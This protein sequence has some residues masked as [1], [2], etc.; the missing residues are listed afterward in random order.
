MMPPPGQWIDLPPGLDGKSRRVLP[1][2]VVEVGASGACVMAFPVWVVQI[3]RAEG[4]VRWRFP[5]QPFD[6][7]RVSEFA[8]VHSTLDG[9]L[10]AVARLLPPLAEI[11][12]NTLQPTSPPAPAAANSPERIIAA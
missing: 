6:V 4:W 3:N 1:A 9:A 10:A 8:A 11:P 5:N 12:D 2:F 7:E